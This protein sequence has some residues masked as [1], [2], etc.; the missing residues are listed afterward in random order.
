MAYREIVKSGYEDILAAG[1]VLTG[2]TSLLD[3]ITELAEHVFN[4]PVRKGYPT[5]V[6]G[7][8]DVIN[9]PI[10]ATGVGLVMYGSKNMSKDPK[11]EGNIFIST[12]RKIKR[13]FLEFF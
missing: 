2:G 10:Y 11:G 1:I 7:L 6:G 9:S 5:G 4:M 8:T 13:W 12:T 3:G